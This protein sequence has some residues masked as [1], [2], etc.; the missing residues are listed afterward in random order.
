MHRH[1]NDNENGFNYRV[2]SDGWLLNEISGNTFLDKLVLNSLRLSYLGTRFFIRLIFGKKRR[3][4]LWIKHKITFHNFLYNS[5]EFLRLDKSLLIVFYV[6]S[7]DFKF[8]CRITRN[9]NNFLIEDVYKS[10]SSHEDDVIEHF[11]P[12]EGDVVV[13]VGA[14]FGFYSILASRKVKGSGRVISIEP[15]PDSFE[16][17]NCNIKLNG[18][19]NITTLNYAVFSKETTLN[20]YSSYSILSERSEKNKKDFVKVNGNTLEYLLK[21]LNGI[22]EVNWIKIDVEG[23]E[24]EV[25]KGA[26]RIFSESKDLSILMEVHGKDKFSEIIDLLDTYNFKVVYEKN[27]EWGDKHIILRKNSTTS[28]D[29]R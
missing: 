29:N 1:Q 28:L 25:L 6:P 19:T 16:M 3:D 11:T 15:Q 13:D 7:Y 14:A 27:Y 23:A 9:V 24:L 20:L 5:I 26:Q 2:G 4:S 21:E 17:L 22:S 8:F 12:K 10:M 18:L